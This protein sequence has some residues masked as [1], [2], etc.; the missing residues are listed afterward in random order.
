MDGCIYMGERWA[1]ILTSV[2]DIEESEAELGLKPKGKP[3]TF[4][5]DKMENSLVLFFFF[6]SPVRMWFGL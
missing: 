5:V 6:F 1:G 4:P 3:A 2:G